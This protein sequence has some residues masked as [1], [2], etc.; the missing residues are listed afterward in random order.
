MYVFLLSDM[1]LITTKRTVDDSVKYVV[2]DLKYPIPQIAL[3]AIT[4]I[5]TELTLPERVRTTLCV[6]FV[7]KEGGGSSESGDLDEQTR[8]GPR[9]VNLS[10]RKTYVR[11]IASAQGQLQTWMN[12]LRKAQHD[13]TEA[14][15]DVLVRSSS[16]SSLESA[17]EEYAVTMLVSTESKSVVSADGK[18]TKH[19]DDTATSGVDWEV[20]W[21][22]SNA[23]RSSVND[24]NDGTTT[25]TTLTTRSVRL[26]RDMDG[27]G[28]TLIGRNPVQFQEV[29]P[30]MP[31]YNA[32]V[33][34]G[35]QI[36]AVNGQECTNAAHHEVVALIKEALSKPKPARWVPVQEP[37][38]EIRS[39]DVASM[40]SQ[41]RTTRSL[42]KALLTDPAELE[43]TR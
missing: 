14:R 12:H 26:V 31:A 41:G 30:G 10:S 13:L 32:G 43:L 18:T 1:I 36:R 27:L 25:T 24:G 6:E 4:N 17:T 23:Q 7:E 38:R 20:S 37:I 11:F 29:E 22:T 3:S 19:A 15:R 9:P 8:D 39:L 33:R 34:L 21:S 5:T 28:F 35:D 42:R 16:V 2:R 40:Q